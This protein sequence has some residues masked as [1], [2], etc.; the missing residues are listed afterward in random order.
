VSHPGLHH[1]YWWNFNPWGLC[2][3][4]K[5][6]TPK[7]PQFVGRITALYDH[8]WVIPIAGLSIIHLDIVITIFST[9]PFSPSSL[10]SSADMPIHSYLF[11][12]YIPLSNIWKNIDS[13]LPL[14]YPTTLHVALICPKPLKWRRRYW[15][16]G[17]IIGNYENIMTTFR[18]NVFRRV[19]FRV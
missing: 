3:H 9:V 10:S 15:V 1:T 8:N 4:C 11:M 14:A 5:G 2:H 17:M 13:F 12:V 18:W 16:C 7:S 19:E 6:S